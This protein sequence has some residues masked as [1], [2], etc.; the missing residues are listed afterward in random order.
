MN[1]NTTESTAQWESMVKKKSLKRRIS[2]FRMIWFKNSKGINKEFSKILKINFWKESKLIL[3][4]KN[5]LLNKSLIK[6]I[7]NFL[8]KIV[9]Q[10]KKSR[11][12]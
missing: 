9:T 1:L 4:L 5:R 11:K 8:I 3:I 7:Y 6:M 10:M 2:Q 12:L